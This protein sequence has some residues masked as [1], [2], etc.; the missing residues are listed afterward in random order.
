MRSIVSG[1]KYGMVGA[2]DDLADARLRD[3]VPQAFRREHHR[4]DDDLVLEVLAR[5]AL[6]RA[7]R[8]VADDARRI[9]AAQVRR[10]VAAAMRR[11][12]DEAREAIERAVEDH[13]AQEHRRLERIA[14]DVA[15]AAAAVERAL[16]RDV[17][18]VVRMHE[19]RHAELLGFG[20]ERVVLL[21]R[22]RLVVDVA[23]DRRAAEPKILHG[24]LELLGGEI[25]ELQRDRAQADE[26]RRVLF[27]PGREAF[28]VRR[29][30]GARVLAARRVPPIRIDAERLDVDAALVHR[31]EPLGPEHERRRRDARRVDAGHAPRDLREHAMRV[32]V[33]DGHPPAADRDAL[34]RGLAV[35]AERAERH[36]R[37]ARSLQECPAIA[38]V[39]VPLEPSVA[40][41]PGSVKSG[42]GSRDFSTLE[43][44]PSRA[45]ALR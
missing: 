20:P 35:G 12:D 40:Q 6:V 4:V 30:D 33:D 41:W 8:V 23:A 13:A 3:E 14:D 43:V 38:H 27:A 22:R 44:A 5:L 9:A 36:R 25:R 15:Q 11:A 1:Q 31:R 10:Q 2:V 19:H 42:A 21:A 24:M 26:A 28:V 29:D 37:A 39:L 32:H 45:F 17:Q 16:A 34:R 18:R 7:V